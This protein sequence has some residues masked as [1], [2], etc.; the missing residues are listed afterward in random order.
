MSCERICPL[1][2]LVCVL[3]FC[4]CH[5]GIQKKTQLAL[6]SLLIKFERMSYVLSQNCLNKS[7]IPRKKKKACLQ[8]S[9][10]GAIM[11][12]FGI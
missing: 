10:I 5:I 9:Y 1:L 3:F 2:A 4:D 7:R 8:N 12:P 11:H 6:M